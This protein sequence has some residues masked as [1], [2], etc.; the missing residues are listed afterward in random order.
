MGVDVGWHLTMG[1]LW[2]KEKRNGRR[3]QHSHLFPMRILQI[4]GY[5]LIKSETVKYI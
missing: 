3:G 5:Q 1:W 2:R 4:Y